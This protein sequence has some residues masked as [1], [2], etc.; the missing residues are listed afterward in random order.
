MPRRESKITKALL[1]N[2]VADR[3]IRPRTA[4][5]AAADEPAQ[6][7]GPVIYRN[8]TGFLDSCC[9][10]QHLGSLTTKG[11]VPQTPLEPRP[12][13]IPLK[14]YLK[15]GR[16]LNRSELPAQ[17]ALLP[18]ASTLTTPYPL[19][20]YAHR[21]SET[22]SSIPTFPALLKAGIEIY[23][24]QPTMI[25]C[26]QLVVDDLWVSIGSANMDNRSFRLNDEANLNVMDA[27]FA[28]EQIKLFNDD[29]K[30]SRQITY[31]LWRN[32]SLGE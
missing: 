15:L 28:A 1:A 29:L 24:F 21:H 19:R 16:G 6:A 11:F 26:K 4:P 7:Q 30:R 23:E 22:N 8:C 10:G 14:S 18:E 9:A 5:R 3:A 17:T 27:P 20:K 2:H 31:E 12:K 32:R 25:H 13:P